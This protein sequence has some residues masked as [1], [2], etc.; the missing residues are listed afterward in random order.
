MHY[1]VDE[2]VAIYRIFQGAGQKTYKSVITSYCT[3]TKLKIIKEKGISRFSLHDFIEKAGN[4]TIFTPHE[5][6]KIYEENSNIVM[7]EM[8][9][10]GYF[11]KGHNVTHKELNDNGLFNTHP[12]KIDYSKDEFIKILEMGDVNVQNVII[13]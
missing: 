8:V 1:T 4:K 5:L 13:D 12:Y 6:K 2:P 3:I 10:N 11:G 7:L 9:Y